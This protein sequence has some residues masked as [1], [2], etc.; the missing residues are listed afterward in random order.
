M[1]E[2]G[3]S[4]RKSTGGRR[5]PNRKK[6]KHRMAREQILA[7]VMPDVTKR[8][9]IR[10]AGGNKKSKL[11]LVNEAN[12]STKEGTKRVEIKDVVENPAN[13]HYVRRNLVTKGAIIETDAGKAVVTSRPSQHGVVN[14]KLVEE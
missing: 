7:H 4:L 13:V 10:V 5:R 3:K 6:K 9:T 12:L 14:A 2:Q 1:R 11:L 8:K